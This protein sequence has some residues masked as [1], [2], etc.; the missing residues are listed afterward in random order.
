MKPGKSTFVAFLMK[1]FKK[2]Y[3]TQVIKLNY[4]QTLKIM[5]FY[6]LDFNLSFKF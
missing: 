1:R 2:G 4:F 6:I 5:K 3:K